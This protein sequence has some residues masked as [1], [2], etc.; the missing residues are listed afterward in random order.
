MTL[1]RRQNLFPTANITS[2]QQPIPLKNQIPQTTS[3]RKPYIFYSMKCNVCKNLLIQLKNANLLT[4]F[5]IK[6]ID[7]DIEKIAHIGIE[8]VPSILTPTNQILV[9]N[10]IRDYIKAIQNINNHQSN[11]INEINNIGLDGF[12]STEMSSLSDRFTYKDENNN[13]AFKQAYMNCG[14]DEKTPIITL[15]TNQPKL[16]GNELTNLE[17]KKLN[18]RKEQEKNIKEY[19]NIQIK[20]TLQEK[21]TL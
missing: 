21:G 6:C 19:Y 12:S 3:N 4:Y 1:Q 14:D 18:E 5:T 10:K 16:R 11:P 17:T 20:K 15:H 2:F 7:D 9:D 13:K 8:K